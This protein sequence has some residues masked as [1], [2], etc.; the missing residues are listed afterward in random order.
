MSSL[1]GKRKAEA[2]ADPNRSSFRQSK[3][4]SDAHFQENVPMSR[5]FSL[6]DS[7]LLLILEV[8]LSLPDIACFDSAVCNHRDR[9]KLLSLLQQVTYTHRFELENERDIQQWLF[10]RQLKLKS[11]YITN[12][13]TSGVDSFPIRWSEVKI[14]KIS[15]TNTNFVP[16]LEKC[17]NIEDL[18]YN[19]L[20]SSEIKSADVYLAILA[21]LSARSHSSG[22]RLKSLD[23]DDLERG[24]SNTFS[25][26][27]VQLVTTNFPL[28]EGLTVSLD[29]CSEETLSS[30]FTTCTQLQSLYIV[31][32]PASNREEISVYP[33]ANLRSLDLDDIGGCS[34]LVRLMSKRFSKLEKFSLCLD[35]CSTEIISELLTNYSLLQ[36]LSL[37]SSIQNPVNVQ[38]QPNINLIELDIDDEAG[39]CGHEMLVAIGHCFPNLK[40]L[41]LRI[42]GCDDDDISAIAEGCRHLKHLSLWNQHPEESRIMDGSLTKCFQNCTQLEMLN[43]S[44]QGSLTD[45]TLVNIT[46]YCHKLKRFN[47]ECDTIRCR[48]IRR[49][50]EKVEEPIF[51]CPELEILSF[52]TS[53]INDN[54]LLL[55]LR[56]CPNIKELNIASCTDISDV[57]V[58]HISTYCNNLTSLEFVDLNIKSSGMYID[59]I[60]ENNPNLEKIKF[61]FFH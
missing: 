44:G 33:N 26:R 10:K 31:K 35:P 5:I 34:D 29:Q 4:F 22:S 46:R 56:S 36:R 55:M 57:A 9:A 15:S 8:W 60:Y 7:I 21:Y 11:I 40:S 48:T 49:R 38:F 20:Y 25:D 61:E 54:A 1:T 13:M 43:L 6:P 59:Q 51:C 47:L 18:S 2:E 37:W 16:V 53:D 52:D 41:V 28:L 27:I 45:L 39:S 3:A 30:L 50:D 19:K 23:F 32:L 12:K 17:T 42:D 24:L 58:Y 14:V